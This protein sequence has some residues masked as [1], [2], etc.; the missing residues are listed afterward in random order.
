[1][2]QQLNHLTILVNDQEEALQFYV[3]KLGFKKHTDAPFGNDRWLTVCPQNQPDV[4]FVL[5]KAQTPEQMAAVGKQAGGISM[6]VLATDDCHA[7]YKQ[8][9]N[10]GVEFLSEPVR[11]PWG[12]G[13]LFKDLYGNIFYLNQK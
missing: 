6:A 1:M 8:L 12:T 7:D 9:K 11:E 5:M 4:E 2:I 13:A 3:D 10:R